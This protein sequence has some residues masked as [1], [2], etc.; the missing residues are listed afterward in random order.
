MQLHY[1]NDMSQLQVTSTL[2]DR[3]QTTV[4]DV[5]RKALGLSKRDQLLYT[6]L[7]NGE[8]RV[9]KAD[10]VNDDVAL[11]AFLQLLEKDIMENPQNLTPLTQERL[12]YWKTLAGGGDVDL[13]APL[14]NEDED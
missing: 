11:R 1:F 6:V 9:Q 13:N 8:I 2:T 4:P 3:Y 12:A 5:V 7:D 10:T 14:V